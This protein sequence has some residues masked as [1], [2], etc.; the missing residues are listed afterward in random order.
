M[1][2]VREELIAPRGSARSRRAYRFMHLRTWRGHRHGHCVALISGELV[3]ACP[4]C[5]ANDLVDLVTHCTLGAARARVTVQVHPPSR[6][7]LAR[8]SACSGVRACWAVL[9]RQPRG[10]R[11]HMQRALPTVTVV[12]SSKAGLVFC[13]PDTPQLR[14]GK[15]MDGNCFA[16]ISPNTGVQSSKGQCRTTRCHAPLI[17]RHWQCWL[18]IGTCARFYVAPQ[19]TL[20]VYRRTVLAT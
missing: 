2:I 19:V 13:S 20:I 6:T 15:R 11:V 9:A 5:L 16:N 8:Y 12:V 4:R 17:S 10:L 3:I 7:W 1:L 14:W 18:T